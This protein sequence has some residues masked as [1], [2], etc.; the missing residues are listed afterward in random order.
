MADQLPDPNQQRITNIEELR[1]K[2]DRARSRLTESERKT[3][4]RLLKFDLPGSD[5][6]PF[7][8]AR[9]AYQ[10]VLYPL[11]VTGEALSPAEIGYLLIARWSY[12]TDVASIRRR[13]ALAVRQGEVR[14]VG[15]DRYAA[16]AAAI[17]NLRAAEQRW[18]R[19]SQPR[20]P[21]PRHPRPGQPTSRSLRDRRAPRKFT[22]RHDAS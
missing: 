19:A 18:F 4:D 2:R 12:N 7:V 11:V 3:A 9:T 8:A 21:M 13:L 5:I 22:W 16:N 1:A 6:P 15:D 20:P 17:E 10:R 14:S